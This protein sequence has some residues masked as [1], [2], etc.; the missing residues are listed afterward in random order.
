MASIAISP[1][2]SSADYDFLIP[3]RSPPDE[4]PRTVWLDVK[5]GKARAWVGGE[6]KAIGDLTI[7][8]PE[9]FFGREALDVVEIDFFALP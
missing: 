4:S 3:S 9:G 2:I 5:T 7:E 8:D 1:G 6:W